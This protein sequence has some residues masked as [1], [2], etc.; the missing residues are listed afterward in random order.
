M[1]Q[2]AQ[3][4]QFLSV[5][6]AGGFSA[7]AALRGV[8]PSAPI[9]AVAALEQRL[10]V[11]LFR[12]TTRRVTITEEGAAYAVRCR[13]ILAD[14]QEADRLTRESATEL[15]GLIRVTAPIMLGRLHIAPLLAQFLN[16]HPKLT[17][18]FQL[19]DR[20]VDLVDQSFDLGIRIGH[21]TDSSMIAQQV[22]LVERVVCAS[23][24]Y[25]QT[26]GKPLIP[27]D[28]AHHRCVHFDGY[29]PHSEWVFDVKGA[30]EYV[31]PH[32]VMTTSHLDAALAACTAGIG[33]G[34]FLSYQV[35]ARLR[36]R[37]LTRV[38]ASYAQPALPL[39]LVTAP[40]RLASNRI[41]TLKQWLAPRMAQRLKNSAP[42]RT[43]T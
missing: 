16:L 37:S 19:N 20:V 21:L 34:V 40:G 29:A 30:R 6:D 10:N 22:A 8:A 42:K 36:D 35:D 13:R 33:C 9:R 11:Q 5:V 23:A 18:D 39:S 12:R 32:T 28:L 3:L 7:A 25:W 26:H 4:E 41:K 2:L 31:R 43:T 14:L 27:G 24:E 38:L 17:I 1:D 15:S